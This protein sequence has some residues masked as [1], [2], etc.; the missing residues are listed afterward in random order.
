[1]LAKHQDRT[2]FVA[3]KG[4]YEE[5]WQNPMRALLEDLNHVMAPWSK[6]HRLAEPKVHRIYRDIRFSADKS[7]YKTYVS[8]MLSVAAR[9]SKITER[10]AAIYVHMGA[11]ERIIA[12]GIYSMDAPTLARFRKAVVAPKSGA[13]LSKI[14]TP[15]L[16]KKYTIHSMSQ[17]QRVPRG[18]DPDHPRAEWLKH[19]GLIVGLPEPPAKL[20]TSAALV[21]WILKHAKPV[22]PLVSWLLKNV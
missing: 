14:L 17:L 20:L 8:G 5:G 2:W 16:K 15:L 10:A 21:P 7:P 12:A 18:F 4:E 19:K 11:T 22:Q 13:E 1:A 6:P 3:H 9:G